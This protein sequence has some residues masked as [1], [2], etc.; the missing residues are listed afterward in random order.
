M[1]IEHLAVIIFAITRIIVNVILVCQFA[2]ILVYAVTDNEW[3]C[4]GNVFLLCL[5]IWLYIE[6]TGEYSC[7]VTS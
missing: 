3:F 2:I 4:L 7:L 1:N 5:P 6:P